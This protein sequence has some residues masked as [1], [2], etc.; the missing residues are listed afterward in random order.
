[1]ITKSVHYYFVNITLQFLIPFQ[2]FLY[3]LLTY[4]EIFSQ[5]PRN[6]VTFSYSLLFYFVYII[7]LL[8]LFL[9]FIINTAIRQSKIHFLSFLISLQCNSLVLRITTQGDVYKRQP[10]NDVVPAMRCPGASKS[11]RRWQTHRPQR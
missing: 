7:L 9:F 10:V 8:I 1:M 3:Q 5:F 2:T 4:L 11:W 6:F